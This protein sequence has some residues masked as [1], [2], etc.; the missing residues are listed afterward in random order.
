L[1]TVRLFLWEGYT[2]YVGPLADGTEHRHHA[3]Q[4]SFGLERPFQ[5]QI[6]GSWA[7]VAYA[8]I[9]AD[10]PHRYEG[11]QSLQ[12]VVL[13]DGETPAAGQITREGVYLGNPPEGPWP[14]VPTDMKSARV[15][16]DWV[17]GGLAYTPAAPDR[18]QRIR[19][20]LEHIASPQDRQFAAR[21]LA[22]IA[23]LSEDHFLHLFSRTV[24]LPLRRYI[25][26]R[27]ILATVEAIS[28]GSDLTKAAGQGGFSDSAHFSRVFRANFGLA[29]S[30]VLKNSRFI[31]VFT[32][33]TS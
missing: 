7:E 31:Q 4:I 28:S 25:L 5:L 30:A 20:V 6:D 18:D 32:D 27:R 12:L 3:A 23:C 10:R 15:L 11:G 13:L 14:P 22:E 1:V 9:P 33:R 17:T 24:G 16:V 21:D 19:R 26:W 8:R 2:V 29:P